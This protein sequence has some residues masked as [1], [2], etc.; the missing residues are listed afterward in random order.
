M[1]VSYQDDGSPP[2]R[3]V[4][5]IYHRMG[6]HQGFRIMA[7]RRDTLNPHSA[8][9]AECRIVDDSVRIELARIA[10]SGKLFIF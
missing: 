10:A 3:F 1:A 5:D 7:L 2:G 8:L 9:Q 6:K 4:G